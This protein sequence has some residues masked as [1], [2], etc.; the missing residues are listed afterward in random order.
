MN[1]YL[2]SVPGQAE[3][4]RQLCAAAE[5]PVHAYMF[6]GPAGSGKLTAA[7]AFAACLLDDQRAVRGVHPDVV[8]VEREGA[9]INVAQAREIARIAARSPLEGDRKVLIL[10]EF[11]LVD[12]AAP[13]L[14]KTIEEAPLSTVFLILAESVPRELVTVASRCVRIDFSAL[15]PAVIA[16]VLRGEGVDADRAEQAAVAAFGNLGRARL[17]AA[18]DEVVARREL[19]RNA[20]SSLEGTGASIAQ[21][22][23]Q[24]V[25]AI[26]HAT[27][28]L[29]ERQQQ[30]RQ[31]LEVAAKE[32]NITG[33][34]LKNIDTRHK[35]ELRRLRTDELRAGFATL[36]QTLAHTLAETSD[37]AVAR[38]AETGLA[39]V[40]WA[41]E[42][43]I[44]NPNELLLL[45][46]LFV[47]M[48]ES[49][50]LS[51]SRR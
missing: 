14:L 4:V 5:R 46:G 32:K 21:L 17:L 3:A 37:S 20:P 48:T 38:R 16:E 18:D 6:V 50:A 42:T 11:H 31:Q 35:R 44:F 25:A 15:T 51:H 45:H 2:D 13:A 40:Q 30:E 8:Y 28:P 36:A 47:R 10:D 1:N 49:P 7:Y 27:G 41:S 24:I 26:D 9:S 39:S 19:W 29:V 33:Q 22:A 34:A 43:I 12:E 23:D